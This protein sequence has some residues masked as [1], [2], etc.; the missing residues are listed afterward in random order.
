M[1]SSLGILKTNCTPSSNP[2]ICDYSIQIFPNIN[3]K[4]CSKTVLLKPIVFI[5]YIWNNFGKSNSLGGYRLKCQ[6]I[7]L[8][9]SC[10]GPEIRLLMIPVHSF[11]FWCCC[12]CAYSKWIFQRLEKVIMSVYH[13]ISV[14][15]KM[16]LRNSIFSSFPQKTTTIHR[17][18]LPKVLEQDILYMGE[19]FL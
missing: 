1:V 8:E 7:K 13:S 9:F 6:E 12:V 4:M 17:N 16:C 15:V 11:S 18:H 2:A 5:K 3:S 19:I 14:K 10:N